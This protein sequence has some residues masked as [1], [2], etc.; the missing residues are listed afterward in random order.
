MVNVFCAL[1]KEGVYSR[2]FFMETTITG[3]VYLDMFKQ[4]LIPQL[5]EDEQKN[6]FNFSNTAQP[7]ITLTSARIPQHPFPRWSGVD[8][9][10]T[11]FPEIFP[12]WIFLIRFR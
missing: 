4:F 8:S 2:F 3:F 1:S 10:A 11:S 9:M 12:P 6:A 5:D 7:L